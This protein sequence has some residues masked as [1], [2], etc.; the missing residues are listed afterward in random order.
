MLIL[1][2]KIPEITS[3]QE[4]CQLVMKNKNKK[5]PKFHQTA[6]AELSIISLMA[7]H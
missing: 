7:Y 5:Y 3:Q 4:A 2:G 1:T 6:L